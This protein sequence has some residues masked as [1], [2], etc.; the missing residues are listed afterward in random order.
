MYR[1]VLAVFAQLSVYHQGANSRRGDAP[2]G[3]HAKH[4]HVDRSVGHWAE[5]VEWF[6][7]EGRSPVARWCHT[8]GHEPASSGTV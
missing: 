8:A 3:L 6:T 5:G 7:G 1:L 4:I 2:G